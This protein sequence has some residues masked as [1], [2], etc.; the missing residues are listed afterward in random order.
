[1]LT[2]AARDIVLRETGRKMLNGRRKQ[3]NEELKEFNITG[4]SLD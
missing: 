2:I 3:V 1:M 4:N